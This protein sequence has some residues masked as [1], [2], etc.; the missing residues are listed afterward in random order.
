LFAASLGPKN[1]V[2]RFDARIRQGAAWMWGAIKA[3]LAAA[4]VTLSGVAVAFADPPLPPGQQTNSGVEKFALEWFGRMRTGAIDRAQLTADYS[5]QLTD[6]AVQGMSQYL[7]KYEY[8]AS[9]TGARVLQTRTIGEQT[10]YVVKI[11]FP[12]GDAASLMFGVNSE[13]K[14]T[15]ISLMSMAG[16]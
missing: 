14:I 3:S 5:A 15:G 11:T 16:D 6:N 10:F 2:K 12:R 1:A 9:P 13:G 7:K 8:G 4:L